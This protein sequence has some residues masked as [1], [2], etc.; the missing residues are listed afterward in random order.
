VKIAI[1]GTSGFSH[2]VAD[3]CAAS[4]YKNIVLIKK[5]SDVIRS[6]KFMILDESNVNLLLDEGYKFIIGIGDNRIRKEISGKYQ[7]LPFTNVIHPT[8]SFGLNQREYIEEKTGNIIAAGVR[9]TNG[10]IIGNFGIYNLNCTIGH[11]CIIQDYI[12]ICPGAN[13]SGNVTIQKG[14]FIGTNACIING[15]SSTSRITIGENV[16]VAAGAVVV[17]DVPD[18]ATVMGVPAKVVK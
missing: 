18:G 7:Y 12:N 17:R 4:G 5:P 11:D 9:F 8:A 13:I 1:F 16:V 14:A 15:Q 6:S 3:I 2:E 10:I